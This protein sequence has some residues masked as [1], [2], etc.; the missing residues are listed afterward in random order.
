[1]AYG[2]IKTGKIRPIKDTILVS[3][4][5]FEERITNSGIVIINDDMKS[6][7]IRPRWGKIYALGPDVQGLEVGQYIMIAHG[8][9]TRGIKIE[10]ENGEVTVRKVDPNDILLISDEP[11]NDLTMSDKAI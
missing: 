9:W 2:L 7:G 4:M 5:Q 10:D 8:R 1:M 3:D 6:S 11:V